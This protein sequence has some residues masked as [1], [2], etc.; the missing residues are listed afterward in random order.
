MN[1]GTSKRSSW[2]PYGE[3]TYPSVQMGN[4]LAVRTL[5][6]LMVAQAVGCW[7]LLEQPKGS[8][9]ELLPPFQEFLRKV[10]VW[11]HS[12]SMGHYGAPSTKPTWLYSSH[13]MI[14]ELPQFQ[15]A[16]LPEREPVQM[17][18]RYKDHAG[19]ERVKGGKDLKSSQSYPVQF[20]P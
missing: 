2:R 15:P 6:L 18:V 19:R 11:K 12:L 10:R 16:W 13:I 14:N 20:Y 4:C 9:M 7:W 8:T 17:A 3:E 1:I 5:V